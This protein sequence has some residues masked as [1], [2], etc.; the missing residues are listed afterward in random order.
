[1]RTRMIFTLALAL[2]PTLGQAKVVKKPSR[3]TI[4]VESDLAKRKAAF[5]E[6]L[7]HLPEQNDSRGA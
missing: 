3:Q 4:Q 6:G 7:R 2:L 1:M 5:K